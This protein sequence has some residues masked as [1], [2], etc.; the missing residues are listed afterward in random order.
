MMK[1]AGYGRRILVTLSQQLT[2]ESA[3]SDLPA[4]SEFLIYEAENGAIKLE[5]RFEGETVW[6][7][8]QLMAD[9]FQTT[10]Q[11]VSLHL[12]NIYEEGELHPEATHKEF[13]SVRR[14]GKRDVQRTLDFYNLDASISTRM[15]DWVAKLDGFLRLNERD[16]LTHAGRLTHDEAVG[17]AT[18]E[19]D[20]FHS[21]RLA[22]KAAQPDD[23]DK[24]VRALAPATPTRRKK[25]GGEA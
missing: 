5:V 16:I 3:M 25:K 14:E 9:L 2:P 23:F 17:H 1:K 12:Q 15:D 19:Y 4:Q 24:V 10:Q 7:S 18:Q 8:Q 20:A 13:L 21:E 22:E 6:L 11:N